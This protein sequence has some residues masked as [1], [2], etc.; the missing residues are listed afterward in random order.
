MREGDTMSEDNTNTETTT[1]PAPATI[2]A[3]TPQTPAA[4]GKTFTEEYVVSLREEAK[5]NRLAKKNLEAKL[6]NLIGLKE[7]EDIDDAK[8]TSY[9]AKILQDNA[10]AI[11]TANNRLIQAEIK[12]LE[13]YDT[14]L[15]SK[16]L[17]KSE[18]KIADDGTV[19]G[20]KEALAKLELEFPQVKTNTP[21]SPA[22]PAGAGAVTEKQKLIDQYDEAEK[23]RNFPLMNQIRD[24]IKRMKK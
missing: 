6:R 7:D 20:I 10:T 5:S 23:Q 22:N 1:T 17:D 12:N 2:P 8:I 11:T 19:T 9:Q 3:V 18:V 13:G 14:K 16:L 24:Q 21:G 4:Q 15:V